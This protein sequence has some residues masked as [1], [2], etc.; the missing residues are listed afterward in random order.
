[1]ISKYFKPLQA[2]KKLLETQKKDHQDYFDP[3]YALK[4]LKLK[5]KEE[6]PIRKI[7]HI[8]NP[9]GQYRDQDAWP[10]SFCAGLSISDPP[11]E[12]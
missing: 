12:S 6:R 2:L 9:K 10:E 8:I 7:N 11:S 1:M 3:Q 4:S 5:R